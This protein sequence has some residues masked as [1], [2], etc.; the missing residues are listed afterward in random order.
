[1]VKEKKEK[2]TLLKKSTIKLPVVSN[3]QLMKSFASSG[4]TMFK[5][6]G[7]DYSQPQAQPEQDNRSLFFKSEWEREKRRLL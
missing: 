2:K 4:Y 3:R 1:M 5:S 6:E 7:R